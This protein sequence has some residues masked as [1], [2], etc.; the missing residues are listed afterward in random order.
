MA[1]KQPK[2]SIGKALRRGRPAPKKQPGWSIAKALRRGAKHES[3]EAGS[4]LGKA[5]SGQKPS[6]SQRAASF[7]QAA[8]RTYGM[9]PKVPREKPTGRGR[10]IN[11][12][13]A[14]GQSERRMRRLANRGKPAV[15][16]KNNSGEAGATTWFNRKRRRLSR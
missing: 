13:T 10:L 3:S 11:R 8:R 7:R 16:R 12:P 14:A 9:A 5:L 2:W 6:D 15:F 1:Y 4:W